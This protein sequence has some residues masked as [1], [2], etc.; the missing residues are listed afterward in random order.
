MKLLLMAVI[1]PATLLMSN[2]VMKTHTDAVPAVAEVCSEVLHL[3]QECMLTYN[4]CRGLL[5]ASGMPWK[6]LRPAGCPLHC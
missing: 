3:K 4:P 1:F 5:V 6:R 2:L